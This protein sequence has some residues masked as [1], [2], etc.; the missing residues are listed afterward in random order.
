M[1]QIIADDVLNLGEI[2]GLPVSAVRALGA[3][4]VRVN[5]ADVESVIGQGDHA[6]PEAAPHKARIFPH[7][8]IGKP[9]GCP[10]RSG[11]ESE[12]PDSQKRRWAG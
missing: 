9:M 3:D 1:R 11:V 6:R 10:E 12:L 7:V 2:D 8:K 4:V 5:D